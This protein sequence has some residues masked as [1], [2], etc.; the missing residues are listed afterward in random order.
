MIVAVDDVFVVPIPT[1]M[2]AIGFFQTAG[3]ALIAPGSRDGVARRW[4]LGRA[5]GAR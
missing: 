5:V 3:N 4:R 1:M 2:K